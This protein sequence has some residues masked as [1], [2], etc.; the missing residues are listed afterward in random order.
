[1]STTIDSLDIQIS[2]N[3]GNSAAK[4]EELASALGNLKNNGKITVAVNG[5]QKLANTLYKDYW[6]SYKDVNP[7]HCPHALTCPDLYPPLYTNGYPHTLENDY[8]MHSNSLTE[9]C[10]VT[11]LTTPSLLE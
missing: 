8:K 5:L 10:K 3:V 11:S 9:K 1:M 7:I 6:T 4:I 2:T